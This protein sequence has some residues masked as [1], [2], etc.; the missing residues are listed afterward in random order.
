[1]KQGDAKLKEATLNGERTIPQTASAGQEVIARELSELLSDWDELADCLG[2]A[3]KTLTHTLEAQVAYNTS[4]DS[5]SK[6]MKTLEGKVKDV[7]L[8]SSL[9]DKLAQVEKLKVS[10]NSDEPCNFDIACF[11]H[12]EYN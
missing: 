7:E 3:Q 9:Q 10:Y 1:M 2:D 6:W 5:L 8:K 12:V 4:C 11:N